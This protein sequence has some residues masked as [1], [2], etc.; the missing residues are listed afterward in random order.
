MEKAYTVQR[1]LKLA[2]PLTSGQ[3]QAL[4]NAGVQ[5][6]RIDGKCVSLVYDVRLVDLTRVIE[7]ARVTLSR[8]FWQRAKRHLY[9][10]KDNNLR[11]G[12]SHVPHCCNKIKKH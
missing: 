1:H 10:F 12:A 8:T 5:N 9:H 6:V 3:I 7:D 4:Q 11:D 2:A